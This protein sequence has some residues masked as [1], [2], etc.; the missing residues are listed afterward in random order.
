MPPR[1]FDVLLI[2][3]TSR[4]SRK[5]RDALIIFERL[6][7]AGVRLVAVSQGIDSDNDQADLLMQVHGMVDS[8]YVKELATKTRRGLEGTFLRGNHVGGRCFGYFNVPTEHPT[9][10]DEHGRP[11][12]VG[13]P[14]P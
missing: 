8:L 12:I 4:L 7:F 6:S 5:T 2:D 13:V 14:S 10:T 9:R 1:P 11:E 3:D